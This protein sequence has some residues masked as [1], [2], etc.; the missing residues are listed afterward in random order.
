LSFL[1]FLLI[2][3]SFINFID[4]LRKK[5]FW[6]HLFSLLIS[7][8][9]LFF[10]GG[11]WTQGFV[12]AKQCLRLFSHASSPFVFVLCFWGRISC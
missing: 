1:F 10:G 12:H 3:W 7:F 5:I 9:F 6:L 4:L 2:C 8:S 11:D